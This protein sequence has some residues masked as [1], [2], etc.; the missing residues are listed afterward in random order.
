MKQVTFTL[1][2][3]EIKRILD[4]SKISSTGTSLDYSNTVLTKKQIKDLSDD[5]CNFV[6][7]R[8]KFKNLYNFLLMLDCL[9]V[10]ND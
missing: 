9:D 1:V 6:A 8:Y 2:A 7:V 4:S 3:K 10:E 5:I